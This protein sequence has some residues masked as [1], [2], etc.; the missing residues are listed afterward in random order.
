MIP[1]LIFQQ[2]R[3]IYDQQR[4]HPTKSILRLN[5]FLYFHVEMYIV[6]LNLYLRVV[7]NSKVVNNCEDPR[8]ADFGF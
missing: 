2:A 8:R 5:F 4:S 7:S 1:K 6:S 3:V